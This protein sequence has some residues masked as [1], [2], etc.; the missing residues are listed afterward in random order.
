VAQEERPVMVGPSGQV[1]LDSLDRFRPE[2][3]RPRPLPLADD[4]GEAKLGVDL[5]AVEAT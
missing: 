2:E 4:D 1:R 5:A 3:D